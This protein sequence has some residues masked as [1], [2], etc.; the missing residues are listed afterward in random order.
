[1]AT[2][3]SILTWEIPSGEEPEGYCPWGHERVGHDLVTKQQ[4][5]HPSLFSIRMA[6]SGALNLA[7]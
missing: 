2:H 6:K 7:V 3:S 5:Y 1:M 4:M